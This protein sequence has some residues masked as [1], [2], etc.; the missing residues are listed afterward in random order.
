[1]LIYVRFGCAYCS[2]YFALQAKVVSD[3]QCSDRHPEPFV[4][5]IDT[6]PPSTPLTEDSQQYLFEIQSLILELVDHVRKHGAQNQP[7]DDVVM[8]NS[9]QEKKNNNNVF[10]SSRKTDDDCCAL[11]SRDA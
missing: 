5:P 2:S 4:R 8:N 3:E 1:M 6:V 11:G 10:N 7:P 9:V